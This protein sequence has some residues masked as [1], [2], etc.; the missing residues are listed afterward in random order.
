LPVVGLEEAGGL[1]D[2]VVGGV[3]VLDGS[4][5]RSAFAGQGPTRV[6]IDGCGS[7]AVLDEVAAAVVGGL[8]GCLELGLEL[9][10]LSLDPV[11]GRSE[12][13]ETL[14]SAAGVGLSLEAL[15]LLADLERLVPETLQ[16]SLNVP[17]CAGC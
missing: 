3:R 10:A 2:R 7:V 5:G 12:V 16:I 6:R 4:E 11:E 8:T 13:L 15:R 9:G 14:V 1:L 17:E